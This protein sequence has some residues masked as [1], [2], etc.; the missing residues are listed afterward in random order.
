MTQTDLSPVRSRACWRAGDLLNSTKEWIHELTQDQIAELD[1][2]LAHA[3]GRGVSGTK[4]SREDFP[5]PTLAPLLEQA[6]EEVSRGFGLFL[7]RGLPVREYSKED[8]STIFWGVGTYVGEP[9]PQNQSGDLLGNLLD[10]GKR[11]DDGNVR[12]YETNEKL[13]FHTDGADI[14]A[15][16]CLRT[17]KSGGGNH[18]VSSVAVHDAMLERAPEL[19]ECLYEPFHVDW[20]GDQAKGAPP[21]YSMPIF[22]RHGGYVSS[23]YL[24]EYI[25]SAQR[26]EGV[27]PLS[28]RQ[29]E[30]LG[31]FDTLCS[32]DEFRVDLEQQPGDMSF[33]SNLVTL[34]ARE[35]F[36][37]YDDPDERRHLRRL[38][39]A[40]PKT[41][42]RPP[43]LQALYDLRIGQARK[44][45]ARKGSELG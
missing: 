6:N 32:S 13:G 18:F 45:R 31:C 35:A 36:E 1:A 3:K 20:R 28:E 34:H 17:S 10:T 29:H 15:L 44:D 27:P 42:H 22:S 40:S 38:W 7:I 4:V 2:A 43:L 39:L 5:L 30:A 33:I 25:E 19:L 23:F 11:T 9:W 16:L 41:D 24:G 21:Y 14:V 37:D 12:Y 8:A 26:Y